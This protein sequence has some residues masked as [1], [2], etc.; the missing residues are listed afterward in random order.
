VC[1]YRHSTDPL[2][3]PP[4][5]ALPPVFV[6]RLPSGPAAGW[7]KASIDYA[8]ADSVPPSNRSPNMMRCAYL[9]S[10]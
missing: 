10:F 2:F 4:M 6:V 3:D 9:S 8:M 5:R 1:G 7:V